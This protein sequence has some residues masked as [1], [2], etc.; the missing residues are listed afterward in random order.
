M[1]GVP[2]ASGGAAAERLDADA[3]KPVRGGGNT[4]AGFD[5]LRARPECPLM[6]AAKRDDAGAAPVDAWR[7]RLGAKRFV[8]CVRVV[9]GRVRDP[10]SDRS[11]AG[12][13]DTGIDEMTNL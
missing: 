2:L 11:E 10:G 1:A 13:T 3:R 4:V 6:G 7:S 8:A 12:V 5:R 9:H